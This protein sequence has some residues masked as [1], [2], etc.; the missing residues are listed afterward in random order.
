MKQLVH[1]AGLI[2]SVITRR[3]ELNDEMMLLA[4][5]LNTVFVVGG[6]VII[7]MAMHQRSKRLEMEHRERLAMI[8]R[9]MLPSPENDPQQFEASLNR[10]AVSR[11]TTLGIAI[12]GVGVGLMLLIGVA[13]GAPEAG[14]GVGGAIAVLGGAFI[15]NGYLQRGGQR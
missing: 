13:G 3:L 9:G 15:A 1:P 6:A 7:V 12:V 14:V 4:L 10:P 11:Y 8:E 5:L 2:A